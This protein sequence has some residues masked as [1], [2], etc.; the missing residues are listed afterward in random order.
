[1]SDNTNKFQ[2]LLQK[3]SDLTSKSIS[4][5]IVLMLIKDHDSGITDSATK[6]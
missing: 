1:M 4:N 6:E 2:E 3:W 5:E